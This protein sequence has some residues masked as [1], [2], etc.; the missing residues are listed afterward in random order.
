[1]LEVSVTDLTVVGKDAESFVADAPGDSEERLDRMSVSADEAAVVDVFV[2]AASPGQEIVFVRDPLSKGSIDEFL[3]GVETVVVVLRPLLDPTRRGAEFDA[4]LI[5][6]DPA[7]R[8][9]RA[10]WEGTGK[11]R[12]GALML[13]AADKGVGPAEAVAWAARGLA[14]VSTEPLAEAAS[15]IFE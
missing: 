5:G 6:L 3:V 4:W 1:V 13:W 9:V 11:E 15:S 12:M 14:G 2:G 8:M 7:G 10:D